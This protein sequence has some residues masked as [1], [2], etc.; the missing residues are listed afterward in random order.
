M[1]LAAAD[2]IQTTMA[3]QR[4]KLARSDQR[5]EGGVRADVLWLMDWHFLLCGWW[6]GRLPRARGF[7]MDARNA[8]KSERFG[9]TCRLRNDV[10]G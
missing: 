10:S 9:D 1:T 5:G 8:A 4:R 3:L 7:A 6:V 2:G